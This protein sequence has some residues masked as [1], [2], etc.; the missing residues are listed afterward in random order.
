MSKTIRHVSTAV[1]L[2]IKGAIA[3]AEYGPEM[4]ADQYRVEVLSAIA[5]ELGDWME[6]D[7]PATRLAVAQCID[8]NLVHDEIGSGAVPDADVE[9]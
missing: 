2:I 3:E 7:A 8:D 6:D 1:G 5:R 4:T 9:A